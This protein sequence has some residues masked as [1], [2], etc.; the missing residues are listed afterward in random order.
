MNPADTLPN[1][2]AGRTLAE[3]RMAMIG[4]QSPKPDHEW[5]ECLLKCQLLSPLTL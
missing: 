3:A 2:V 5:E 4:Y 1:L